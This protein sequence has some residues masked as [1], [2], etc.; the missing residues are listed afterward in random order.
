MKTLKIQEEKKPP[1]VQRQYP[2]LQNI[3]FLN[4]FQ[5]CGSELFIP[6][7]GFEFFHPG[8]ASKNLIIVYPIN[9][10]SEI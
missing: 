8:S 10:F 7:P 9:C 4:F 3:K 5:R 1:E 6:D 2:A